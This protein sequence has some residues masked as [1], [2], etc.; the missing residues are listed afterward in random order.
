MTPDE[1]HRFMQERWIGTEEELE[2]AKQ[3]LYDDIRSSLE[4]A[5][6]IPNVTQPEVLATVD[7]YVANNWF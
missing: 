4:L 1:I 7:D 5:L 3:L 2:R 6:S